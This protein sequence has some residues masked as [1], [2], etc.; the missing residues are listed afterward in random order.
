M[1]LRFL[2]L[3]C[4]ALLA[5]CS[6]LDT[7]QS[8]PPLEDDWSVTLTQTGGFIGVNR[9]VSITADGKVVAIDLRTQQ[10]G[11]LQLSAAELTALQAEVL[12]ARVTG[13]TGTRTGC[14]DCFLYSLHIDSPAGSFRVELDD[15]T[16]PGSGL[17]PLV[18]HLLQLMESAL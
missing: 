11:T 17:Q 18:A 13:P 16:L 10:T 9:S 4:I 15:V 2:S 1:R 12:A 3:L 8:L 6:G 14:A 5:A 7:G